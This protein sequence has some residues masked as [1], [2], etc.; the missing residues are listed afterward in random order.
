MPRYEEVTQRAGSLRA[1]TGLT[2]AECQAL[3]PHVERAFVTSMP[4]RTIDGHPRTS[5]RYRTTATCP[6]PTMAD[7]RLFMLTDVK[8]HPIQAVQGQLFGMSQSHANT[9]IHVL[10]PVFNQAFADHE[11]LPA[12]TAAEFAAMCATHG[13]DRRSTT[14]LVGMMAP[15]VRSIARPLPKSH[16][17]MTVARRSVTRAN[18]AS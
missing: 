11:R 4:E 5:R 9:W 7:K 3:L 2:E 15:N 13:T 12:R 8:Q 17:S 16:K 14:P 18:T 6:L 10:H 1:M